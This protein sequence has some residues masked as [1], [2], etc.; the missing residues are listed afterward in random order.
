MP[1]TLRLAVLGDPIEHSRSP[2]IHN[3]AIRHIGLEG[4]YEARRAGSAELEQAVA[5]LKVGSLDGINVTMPLKGEAARLAEVLTPEAEKSGSV[6]ALRHRQG[7]VEGHSTDVIAA[8]LALSDRRF[9][10]SAPILILGS[11]GAAAAVMVGG[12]DRVLFLSAR[13]NGRAA[14]LAH[15][16]GGDVGMIPFG[17]GVTGAVVVNATPLGMSGEPLPEDVIAPASGLIDLAYADEE[18][19]A[20][21]RAGKSKLAVMD[22]V[23]FLVLQAAASFEWWTGMTAPLEVMLRAAKK[24]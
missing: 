22:G 8:R 5:E 20:V 4:G 21:A 24:P 12:A 18:T 23:E 14:G 13:N 17:S 19:P 1:D 16:V 2:D 6:N 10:T 11:G 9:A 3:A 7:Q 15:R